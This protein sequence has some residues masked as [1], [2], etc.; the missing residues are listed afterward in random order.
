MKIDL[1]VS[2]KQID[3][4]RADGICCESELRKNKSKES[5]IKDNLVPVSTKHMHAQVHTHAHVYNIS[6]VNIQYASLTHF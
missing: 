1:I 6:T 5:T 3:T 2:K 4:G